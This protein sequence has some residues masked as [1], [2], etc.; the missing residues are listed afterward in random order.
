PDGTAYLLY[1]FSLNTSAQSNVGIVK[2]P[3]GGEWTDPAAVSPLAFLG[4]DGAIAF[5]GSD[6][7]AG[8]SADEAADVNTGTHLIEA[9]RWPAGAAMPEG[10]RDLEELPNGEFLGQ[11]L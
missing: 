11:I 8:W 6:A 10:F 1:N 7:I 9:S 2:R 4:R 5:R 3:S